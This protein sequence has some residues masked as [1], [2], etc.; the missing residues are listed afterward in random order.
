MV[1]ELSLIAVSHDRKSYFMKYILLFVFSVF[2]SDLSAQAQEENYSV[3]PASEEQPGVPK[4]EVLK[5]TFDH[6]EIFPGTWREYWVYIPAQYNPD[7]PACVYVNQDG[8]QWKAPTVF[9]NLIHKNEMPETTALTG[10]LSMMVLAMLMHIL[11]SMKSYRMLKNI[12][13]VTEG[14]SNCLKMRMTGRS[15]GRAAVQFVHLR[16]LGNV[17]MRFHGFSAR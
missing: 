14:R 1:A 16:R 9:D 7:K 10:V 17:L 2:I 6:S 5:F 13:P 8:I 12:N 11:S 15:E 3:D 4:G